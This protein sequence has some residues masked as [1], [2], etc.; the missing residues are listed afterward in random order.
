MMSDYFFAA[1]EYLFKVGDYLFNLKDYLIA[2]GPYFLGALAIAFTL[3]T[4]SLWWNK[5]PFLKVIALA[6]IACMIWLIFTGVESANKRLD[7]LA[8]DAN[9]LISRLIQETNKRTE[10]LIKETNA[11]IRYL[12][13][14]LRSQPKPITF[15][16]LQGMLPEGHPGH[17]VLYGE[18]ERNSGIFLLL[19]SPGISEPRYYLLVIDEKL[20]EEFRKA[21]YDAKQK[22]TQL[23]LGG[24][25][26][27]GHGKGTAGQGS[28]VRKDG[29]E[30]KE[31]SAGQG[32]QKSGD[33]IGVFHPAPVTEDS[34][35]KPE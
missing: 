14:T 26:K 19:R 30:G 24:K 16:E 21:E 18:V 9:G 3:A 35:P 27:S 7:M 1:G 29:L 32:T 10:H 13:D 25:Q 2:V 23:L 5:S 11:R 6:A 31:G 20:Q 34:S 33:G 28:G 4:V 8:Q 17:L 15:K 12:L 22:R